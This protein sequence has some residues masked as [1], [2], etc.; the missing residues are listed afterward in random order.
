[1]AKVV[2]M[3]KRSKIINM[4]PTV[5]QRDVFVNAFSYHFRQKNYSNAYLFSVSNC[6]HNQVFLLQIICVAVFLFSSFF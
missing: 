6:M 1:M 3:V 2:L 4:G 5:E